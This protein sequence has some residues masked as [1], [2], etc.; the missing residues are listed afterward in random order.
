MNGKRFLLPAVWTGVL[1][2]CGGGGGSGDAGPGATV[3]AAVHAV[4]VIDGVRGLFRSDDRGATWSRVNDDEHPF[5]GRGNLATD[6]E[7]RGRVDVSGTGR[8]L[9][10]GNG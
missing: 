10:Y 9:L 6:H 8:G 5:G 4:G 1:A 2:G 3:S 7:V